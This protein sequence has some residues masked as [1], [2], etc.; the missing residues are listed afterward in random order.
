M[1]EIPR[2]RLKGHDEIELIEAYRKGEVTESISPVLAKQYR[3]GKTSLDAD[4]LAMFGSYPIWRRIAKDKNILVVGD[5]HAPFIREGY[6]E[7]CM[8]IRD[9]YRCNH[10]IFIGDIV[11]NHYASFHATDPDG[12]GGSDELD[13]AIDQIRP[14]HKEFPNADVVMGNHDKII[15]RK[16]FKEGI[17]KRWIRTFSDILE[18]PT[19]LFHKDMV[20]YDNVK[21]IHGL[22][23]GA[24]NGAMTKAKNRGKSI[25]QGHWH[26][27]SY[28][29]W[30]VT[31]NDRIFAMQ[32]GCGV[33]EDAYAMAYAED[34][35][36]RWILSC[37]I[38]LE[39]GQSA[40]VEPM[41]L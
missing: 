12:L 9:K 36:E 14:W 2:I 22:K 19:W 26:S 5:L 13:F 18:V 1:S 11:D 4:S 32:V 10:T 25:V 35:M 20:E 27:R 31:D 21:Y 24:V 15:L 8:R 39:N 30:H 38:V 28:V 34:P 7:H 6:L 29:R 41:R 3:K 17:S 16:I 40:I 37:G 33:D 23:G